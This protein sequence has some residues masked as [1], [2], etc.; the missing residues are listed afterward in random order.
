MIIFRFLNIIISEHDYVSRR[1]ARNNLGVSYRSYMNLPYDIEFS[2]TKLFEKELNLVRNHE[3]LISDVK[4]R[5]D[6]NTV[7]LFITIQTYGYD[8]LNGDE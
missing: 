3:S 8:Y 7:D 4:A 6:F 2:L 5:Y 1:L